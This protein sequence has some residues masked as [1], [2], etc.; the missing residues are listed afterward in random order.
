MAPSA[1]HRG[2]LKLSVTVRH[3]TG[4]V[5]NLSEGEEGGALGM[6]KGTSN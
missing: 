1:I 5:F 6:C 4:R 2:G 3:Q